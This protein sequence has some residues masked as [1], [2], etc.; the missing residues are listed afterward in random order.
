MCGGMHGSAAYAM[1]KRRRQEHWKHDT[2]LR[3]TWDCHSCQKADNAVAE[4][5]TTAKQTTNSTAN[6]S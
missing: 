4:L 3:Y 5:T 1:Q 2:G 6:A